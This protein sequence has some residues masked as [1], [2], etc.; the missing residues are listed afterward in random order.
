MSIYRVSNLCVRINGKEN[1]FA[2]SNGT[3]YFSSSCLWEGGER[4]E[5]EMNERYP[6]STWHAKTDEIGVI[7][8]QLLEL[9]TP[10]G[11]L[12]VRL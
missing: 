5:K 6:L 1:L 12:S 11:A 8:R 10:T 2:P 4:V 7:D 3:I 9:M